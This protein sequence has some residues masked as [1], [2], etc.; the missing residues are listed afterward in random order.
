MIAKRLITATVAVAVHAMLVAHSAHAHGIA[1]NRYFPG[2]LS[3]DDPAV[4][5]ELIVPDFSALQHP[6][7]GANVVDDRFDFAFARLLTKT[8]SIGID[9]GWTF[10]NWGIVQR[11]GFEPTHITLK[12]EVYRDDLHETLISAALSWGIRR[13]DCAWLKLPFP[14]YP[15]TCQTPLP[16]PP[17]RDSERA[18]SHFESSGRHRTHES[19]SAL[20]A[21]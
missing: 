6:N 16:R 1:G 9:T 12:G 8:L 4:A 10:R 18:Q 21:S 7:A 14:L 19:S 17:P 3:F 15:A 11:S 5:D 13:G 2:T 20:V